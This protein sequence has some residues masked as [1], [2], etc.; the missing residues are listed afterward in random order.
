MWCCENNGNGGWSREQ[1]SCVDDDTM[2]ND[3][4]YDK[5]RPIWWFTMDDIWSLGFDGAE[6][7]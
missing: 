2:R 1:G 3:N 5:A 4:L 6:W 7:H